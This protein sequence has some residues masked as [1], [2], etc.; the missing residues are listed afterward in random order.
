MINKTI[1]YLVRLSLT[2]A[3][4]QFWIISTIISGEEKAYN[5]ILKGFKND[6]SHI[7]NLYCGILSGK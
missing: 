1:K 2:Q 6:N 3:L 5:A 7:S 4:K